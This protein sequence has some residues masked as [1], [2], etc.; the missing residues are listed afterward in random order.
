MK[1][2]VLLGISI[3]F[4]NVAIVVMSALALLAFIS[5]GRK[6]FTSFFLKTLM[7]QAVLFVL[8]FATFL[9][10][11]PSEGYMLQYWGS[12]HAFFPLPN[13]FSF[14]FHKIQ[15]VLNIVFN[16]KYIGLPLLIF[17]S[18]ALFVKGKFS[19]FKPQNIS[20]ILLI[21]HLILS[22][23]KKYPFENR[24]LLYIIPFLLISLACSF[25]HTSNSLNLDKKKHFIFNIGIVASILIAVIY[26]QI[27]N[28]K[29][30]LEPKEDIK[31]L[32]VEIENRAALIDYIFISEGAEVGFL[33]YRHFYSKTMKLPFGLAQEEDIIPFD[34]QKYSTISVLFSHYSPFDKKE[35][36]CENQIIEEAKRKG[37]KISE[38]MQ[39]NR[40]QLLLL[41]R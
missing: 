37:F 26:G 16:N 17:S 23:L 2:G 33:Y 35:L 13:A 12:K 6:F 28:F 39:S 9:Y 21:I 10:K 24:F 22:A 38:S 1:Y 5:D 41:Q 27:K 18:T 7:C 32:M 25:Q 34:K 14:L 8:Y 15:I 31:S 3:L 4:S 30:L 11:H 36:E 19:F 40:S 29:E 20:F